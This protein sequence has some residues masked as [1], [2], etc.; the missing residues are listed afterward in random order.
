MAR[1]YPR[2]SGP[3]SART[4]IPRRS[5]QRRKLDASRNGGKGRFAAFWSK[6]LRV[7]LIL[8]LVG[9]VAGVFFA[10]G[11]YVGLVRSVNQ[12]GTP[13]N[14]ETHP[15]YIY[16]APLGEADGSR[17]VI[18]TI[19]QGENRKTTTLDRMPAHL[20]NAVVAKEDERF[21][22]HAGVDAWGIMRALYVDIRAG[23][24]VEGAS[25]I[26]QQYVRNAYLSQETTIERKVKE[27]LIA[28]QIETVKS[29]DEIL[30][31]YLNTAYFGSNAYG[32][33]AAAETYFN[34]S[35]S[36]LTVAESATLVGLVWSPSTLGEDKA[37]AKDQR[38]LVLRQ[39]FDT[40]YLT[41]QDYEAALEEPM[42][43]EWPQAPMIESG[44]TGPQITRN[45]TEMV[46]D[47][48]INRYG[49]NTVLQGGLTVYT[50]L[51]LEAQ[52]AAQDVIYGPSGYLA[53]PD[54]PDAALISI[55]QSTGE[56]KAMVGNRDQSSQFNLAT[57]AQRQPGSSFKP[58]A[59]IAALEQGIDPSTQFVSENKTYNVTLENGGVEEWEVENFGEAQRGPISLEEALW[60]SDNTVFTDLMMNVGGQ[61]LKNGPQAVADVAKRLGLSADFGPHGHPSIVLGTKEQSPLEMTRAYATIANDGKRMELTAIN[62]V[63]QNEGQ[64]SERVLLQHEQEKGVQAIDAGI[65]RE[66]TSIMLGDVVWGIA[67]DAALDNGQPVAGKTGTSENFF[68]SWFVGYTPELTTGIWM[69]YGEGGATLEDYLDPKGI[70]YGA[71]G[72]PEEIFANYM[73]EAFGDEP[74]KEFKNGIEVPPGPDGQAPPSSQSPSGQ[75]GEQQASGQQGGAGTGALQGQTTD[76]TAAYADP[77]L[78]ASQAGGV[79]Y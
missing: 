61:G 30:A 48:L 29:K 78:N 65:A 11:G 44:L 10:I 25:T 49:A 76:P 75:S 19:F 31:D 22:E 46:Q 6:L 63:V 15:T 17:R 73:T 47:E 50:T 24:V 67:D 60:E 7:L 39:M 8:G 4:N 23:E 32:V 45:F 59:L 68:D 77:S 41:Q 40:G 42:P 56:I 36:D 2:K 33:E 43:G 37:A 35:A 13:A 1:T 16:S 34:K 26:T 18:G 20:L 79:T 21:R 62:R 14:I 28:I 72:S 58:F 38:D 27:A 53:S 9:L 69:G 55:E 12:L 52:Q 71:Y 66:L 70:Y 57:Q 54:A 64:D 3:G 74:V 51:D 5:Q